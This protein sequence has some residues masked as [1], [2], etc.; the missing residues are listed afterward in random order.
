MVGHADFM[1]GG[2]TARMKSRCIAVPALFRTSAL[3]ALVLGTLSMSAWAAPDVAPATPVTATAATPAETPEAH[4]DIWEFAIEGNSILTATQVEQ[5]VTPFLGEHKQLRDV[6]AARAA[7]EK[8]YQ[9]AGYLTVLV[10]L[11]EQEVTGGVVR[12]SVIEGRI[13]RMSVRGSRYFSQGYIRD[14]VPEL[15]DGKVPNFNVVQT[16][17]AEV[18]RSEDRR[19]QPLL[20][21]GKTPGTVEAELKVT[22]QLPLNTSLEVN[23]RHAPYTTPLR[24]Q[25]TLRYD[26][27]FQRDHSLSV[28]AITAPAEPSQS[29]VLALSYA[30]PL[31]AGDAWLGYAVVSDSVIEPLGAATVQGKGFTLGLRRVY[32]LTGL[33][34]YSHTLTLGA[35]FKDLKERLSVKGVDETLSTPLRYMPF[36]LGYNATAQH[37]G[38]AQT[39]ATV[40]GNIGFKGLLRREVDCP[41]SGRVDQFACKTNEADGGFAYARLDVRHLRPLWGQWTAQLRVAGQVANEPLVGAEQ[42]A[43]GGGDTVR[44]YLEAEASGDDAWLGSL[45]VRSPNWASA[46]A[47]SEAKAWLNELGLFLFVDTG[48]VKTLNP[49]FGQVSSTRLGGAGVGVKLRALRTLSATVDVASPFDNTAVTRAHE[50]RWTVRLGAE[51]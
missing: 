28:T 9:D 41:G 3:F 24:A 11:P 20:R 13:D 34:N 19:V 12:L 17:L 44:G 35:D 21:P 33:S 37:E 18:N 10:D 23:N 22:D 48:Q 6:E 31:P 26:N 49:S 8:V 45:E 38:G 50:P 29:K 30:V 25:A 1:T 46:V 47:G 4:F 2:D 51:F 7:L 36:S 42:F 32:A 15:A 27:L 40:T 16:Q 39:T 5:V 14:K 43:L